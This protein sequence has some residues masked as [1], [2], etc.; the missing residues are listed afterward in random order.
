MLHVC[1]D[2]LDLVTEDGVGRKPVRER[3]SDAV[4]RHNLYFIM[5]ELML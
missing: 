2:C 1:I 4:T 5:K 3:S